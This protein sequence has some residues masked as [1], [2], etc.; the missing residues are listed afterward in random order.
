MA[1]ERTLVTGGKKKKSQ[2]T[3]PDKMLLFRV[4]IIIVVSSVAA[5]GQ[6]KQQFSTHVDLQL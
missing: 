1:L 3:G 4:K 5:L 2:C 6:K